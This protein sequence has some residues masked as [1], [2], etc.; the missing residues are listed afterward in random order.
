[1]MQN[2]C[3]LASLCPV[4]QFSLICFGDLRDERE[5]RLVRC[6]FVYRMVRVEK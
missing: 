1:M 4:G 5:G 3:F 2:D 6:K